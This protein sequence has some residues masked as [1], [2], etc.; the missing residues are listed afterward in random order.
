VEREDARQ[1]LDKDAI[2]ERVGGDVEFLGEIADLFV[3][4]CPKLLTEIRS[5]IA[6]RNATALE[7]AAHTL[8]GSV[9]N[10]GAEPARQAAFRL[11]MLGRSGDLQ[12]AQEACTVLE[13]E[14]QRFTAALT[15]LAQQLKLA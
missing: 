1:L 8:K 11:E 9:A 6:A 7:H 15:A 14:V 4:D 3:E 2:L 12:P 10:F 13:Q 5:A